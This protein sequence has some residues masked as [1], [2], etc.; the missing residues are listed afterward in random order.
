MRTKLL[1]SLC[2]LLLLSAGCSSLSQGQGESSSFFQETTPQ[3]MAVNYDGHALYN[4]QLGRGYLAGGRY[5]LARD[6]FLLAL[7]S[8]KNDA[9][10]RDAV[11]ELE[12]V[13][14]LIRSQR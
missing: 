7:A 9:L 3:V 12:S 11:A 4:F 6:S 2:C 10:R 8:S 13:N 5:E 14:R 1:L